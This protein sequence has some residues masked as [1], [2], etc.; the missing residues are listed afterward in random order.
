MSGE[1]KPPKARSTSE[2]RIAIKGHLMRTAVGLEKVQHCFQNG[3]RMEIG[4]DLSIEQDRR[5]SIN[6]IE[7]LNDMLLFAGRICWNARNTFEVD[8][9]FLE[10]LRAFDRAASVR[11]FLLNTI[12]FP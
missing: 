3:L 8:L 6:E 7:D 4:T 9:H 12:V 10:R 5:T 1:G 2:A 11:F